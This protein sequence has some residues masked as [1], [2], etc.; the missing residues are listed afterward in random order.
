MSFVEGA[1]GSDAHAS[2]LHD[3]HALGFGDTHASA[4]N[5]YGCRGFTKVEAILDKIE[6]DPDA[7]PVGSHEGSKHAIPK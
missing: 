1:G 2:G 4:F 6:E 3:T 5:K 7:L